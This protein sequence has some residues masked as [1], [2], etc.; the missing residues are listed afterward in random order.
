MTTVLRGQ[1][2]SGT[3]NE[4]DDMIAALMDISRDEIAVSEPEE[5]IPTFE[6]RIP[7]ESLE[8]SGI[9]SDLLNDVSTAGVNGIPV[10]LTMLEIGRVRGGRVKTI[11]F[12]RLVNWLS[13]IIN[14]ILVY[15]T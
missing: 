15:K 12:I 1:I 5:K 4:I 7:R 2:T 10:L 11:C 14:G 13:S 6:T 3:L 9:S 8:K